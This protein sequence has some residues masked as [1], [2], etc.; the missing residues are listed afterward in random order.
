MNDTL[1]KQQREYLGV[2]AESTWRWFRFFWDYGTV[3]YSPN[4]RQDR[5]YARRGLEA[6]RRRINRV[7]LAVG[8]SAL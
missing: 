1:T 7:R 3:H 2:I 5:L 8:L 6:L 4:R